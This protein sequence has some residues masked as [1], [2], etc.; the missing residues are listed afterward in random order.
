MLRTALL[1][2]FLLV[3]LTTSTSIIRRKI[4]RRQADSSYCHAIDG[5]ECKCSHYRVTCT[6]E[7]AFNAPII[8][9]QD[10]KNKYQS[11]ELVI[12][13][14]QDVQ[15]DDRTFEPVKELYKPDTDNAE[16]RVKFEKFTALRLSSPGL[17][18]RVFPDSLPSNARKHIALEIYNPDVPP[19]DDVHLFQN[20]QADSLELYALYPFHGTFQQIF[21]GANIKYLRLSGGEIRTDV[22]Q[23]FS[24]NIHRLELAKQ[25]NTLS[26]RNFPVYPAH[27]MIINAFYISEFNNENPPNYDNLGE[28]RVHSI[29]NI[30]AGAFRQYP[31]IHTLSVHSDKEI[32]PHAF[33]GLD[34][35]EKLIIKDSKTNME[36]INNLPNVKELETNIEKLDA[37]LQCKLIEK[38]ANGQV[39]VQAIPNGRE[40]TCV[41]AYLDTAA[42]RAPCDA[43]DCDQSSCNAIKNSYNAETRQF[44]PPPPIQRAD[45]TDALRQR[46]P[47]LYTAPFQVSRQDQEKLNQ[48]LPPPTQP[49]QTDE[50]EQRPDQDGDSQ[51][52]PDR[53]QE[54]RDEYGSSSVPS[55]NQP[56]TSDNSGVVGPIDGSSGNG[57]DT[58][59][60]GKRKMSWLP[61]I[62]II[63]A[64]VA[65]LLIGLIFLLIRKKRANKG[66]NQAATGEPRPETGARA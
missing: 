33:D 19:H 3:S 41:A 53:P 47:R 36:H 62:I 60:P 5:F 13:A 37:N 34:R 31:N 42:G 32:D 56:D 64:I 8:I 38:L 65:L 51:Y 44:T 29:E 17:F 48:G 22:S 24:G 52:N 14:I 21:D 55:E 28:L 39:A 4:S 9:S 20:L 10:E 1:S 58:S 66:Y 26:V 16:F 23:P 40:C 35:L 7:R 45:G 57:T 15:V 50:G 54:S 2:L 63:A 27:E 12:S 18:N 30:P 46:E 11:V 6:N 25:A 43:Q 49:P 61:I 59:G